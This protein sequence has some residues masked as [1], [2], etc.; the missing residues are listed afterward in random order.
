MSNEKQPTI[1]T[2]DKVCLLHGETK[3]VLA[4]T[5]RSHGSN[6][7]RCMKCYEPKEYFAAP[8]I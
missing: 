5:Q 1:K 2:A 6:L 3:H 4:R 7:Y 8:K